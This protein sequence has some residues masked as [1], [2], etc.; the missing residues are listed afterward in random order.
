MSWSVYV[1]HSVEGRSRR[2]DLVWVC[3]QP[4]GVHRTP[5][6]CPSSARAERHIHADSRAAVDS[7]GGDHPLPKQV[8]EENRRV[9]LRARPTETERTG[10][11]AAL[12]TSPLAD[13]TFA[14]AA[15]L[16]D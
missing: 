2:S 6:G 4:G 1:N 5:Y 10:K 12:V 15:A 14:A 8:V 13:E 11:E 7:R 9:A 16:V 3:G